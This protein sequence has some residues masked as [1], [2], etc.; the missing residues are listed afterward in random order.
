LPDVIL[1]GVEGDIG[2][3]EKDSSSRFAELGMTF[4]MVFNN[5][6]HSQLFFKR[7]ISNARKFNSICLLIPSLH[8]A[9]RRSDE[10]LPYVQVYLLKK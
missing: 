10:Y 1:G 4:L 9:G 8:A 2:I 7:K 3:V 5:S 6:A